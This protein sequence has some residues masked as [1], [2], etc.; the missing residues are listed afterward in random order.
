MTGSFRIEEVKQM[1]CSIHGSTYDFYKNYQ[2]NDVLRDR[3]N[4]LA[5][6]T[7]GGLSFEKWYREGYWTGKCMPY[8]LFDGNDCAAN[9][10]AS[11]FPVVLN[12]E[13]KTYLQLGTVMTA[14]KYRNRGLVRFLMN[15]I[16]KDQKGNCD[17]V[18]LYANDQVVDFYPKFGFTEEREYQYS[19]PVFPKK[20]SIRKLQVDDPGDRN[21]MEKRIPCGNPYTLIE[22]PDSTEFVMFHCL[23]FQK[24]NL[25]F[26]PEYDAVVVAKQENDT[27]HCYGIFCEDGSHLEDIFS[28]AAEE[29]CSRVCLGFTPKDSCLFEAEQS[30]EEDTHLFVFQGKENIFKDNKIM[31]PVLCRT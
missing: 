31:F 28:V 26:L 14:P 6:N 27:L 7:F 23:T 30:E 3:L 24:D 22:M 12:N 5:G 10:L 13:K 9:I 25:Y 4:L 17:A 11:V 1:K 21:I 15:E 16:L 2:Q 18:Y 20:G 29:N 8:T 19:R